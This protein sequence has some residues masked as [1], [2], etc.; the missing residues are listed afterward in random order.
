MASSSYSAPAGGAVPVFSATGLLKNRDDD[1]PLTFQDLEFDVDPAHG[2]FDQS[3]GQFTAAAAGLYLF[4]FNGC[5]RQY[6]GE[7]KVPTRVELRVDNKVKASSQAF[8]S[9]T[10]AEMSFSL[11][12]SAMFRL[13]KG[14]VVG[15]F[16]P[17]G[18]LGRR[19][20]RRSRQD[21][22]H[23]FSSIRFGQ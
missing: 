19:I 16:N 9:Y 6:D 21:S 17:D 13:E 7:K 5:C 8:S 12:I 4:F 11:S 20:G 2:A 22:T 15:V 1:K 10:N 23:R 18:N 14:S 3:T